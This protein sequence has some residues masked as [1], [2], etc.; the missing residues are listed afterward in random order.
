[1]KHMR[2][3]NLL[4]YV[5]LLSTI[6]GQQAVAEDFVLNQKETKEVLHQCSRMSVDAK[7][8][9]GYWSPSTQQIAEVQKL[10]EAYY[11]SAKT[12]EDAPKAS[13]IKNYNFFYAGLTIGAEKV[14]YIDF[15]P[16]GQTWKG[17][18]CDGGP[19]FFGVEYHLESK[20]FRNLSFNGSA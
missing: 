16:S 4:A 19:Q 2:K 10:F 6:L 14:I 13:D 1:M 9:T 18:V 7:S 5:A 12:P 17:T 20:S 3:T 8:V 15:K 11:T